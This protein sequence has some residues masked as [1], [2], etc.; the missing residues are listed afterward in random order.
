[1]VSR[2]IDR[3]KNEDC[4]DAKGFEWVTIVCFSVGIFASF[5]SRS[6]TNTS[7]SSSS[8]WCSFEFFLYVICILMTLYLLA[9][10]VSSLCFHIFC[11]SGKWLRR[12]KSPV[13]DFCPEEEVTAILLENASPLIFKSTLSKMATESREESSFVREEIASCCCEILCSMAKVCGSGE[14]MSGQRGVREG[15]CR[16]H[17]RGWSD[18]PKDQG[19]R[20]RGEEAV[21][22]A[23]MGR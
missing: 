12:P 20:T 3:R 10:T 5:F 16:D 11:H 13:D 8:F 2:K 18:R 9:P 4:S 14:A 21:A 6:K 22:G 1:M 17:N 7:A 15:R 19:D 23:V